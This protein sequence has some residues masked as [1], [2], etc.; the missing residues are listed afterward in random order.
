MASDYFKDLKLNN[1][2]G[3]NIDYMGFINAISFALR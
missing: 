1:Y 2:S 3:N